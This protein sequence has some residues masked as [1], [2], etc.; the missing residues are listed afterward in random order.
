ML[1]PEIVKIWRQQ[2]GKY[3]FVCT[4]DR[5]GKWHEELFYPSRFGSVGDFIEDNLDKNIYVCPQGFSRPKRLKKYA[6]APYLL[7]ADMDE[8]HPEDVRIPPSYC[9]ETS[10]GRYAGIWLVNDEVTEELNQRLT[11]YIGADKSGWD[12]TQVLRLVPGTYNYKR[13]RPYR[14]EYV[15]RDN[16]ERY[17]VRHLERLLPK[18]KATGAGDYAP[19]PRTFVGNVMQLAAKYRLGAKMM[20]KPSAADRSSVMWYLGMSVLEKGGYV[21]EA[22]AIIRNSAAFRLKY[23]FDERAGEREIERLRRKF[24]AERDKLLGA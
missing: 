17:C 15:W 5:D 13:K 11:Y 4:K 18:L 20:G 7:W 2:P 19:E 22:L 10:P 12:Y 16:G 9:V 24:H 6:V 23:E 14:V 21:S 1:T 3:F 8:V